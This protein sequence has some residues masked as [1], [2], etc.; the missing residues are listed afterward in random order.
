MYGGGLAVGEPT[1]EQLEESHEVLVVGALR[2]HQEWLIQMLTNPSYNGDA[3]ASVLI[4]SD[5]DGL[6]SVH[7]GRLHLEPHVEG[8][9]VGVND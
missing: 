4:Q 7:P 2:K 5:L 8:G 6:L 1:T 9:F 3:I